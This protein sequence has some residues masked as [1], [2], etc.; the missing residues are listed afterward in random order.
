MGLK[1]LGKSL[2]RDLLRCDFVSFS[3]ILDTLARKKRE[4]IIG[5][6]LL[7]IKTMDQMIRMESKI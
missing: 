4:D 5:N 6:K 2:Y 7:T 1:Y 3:G